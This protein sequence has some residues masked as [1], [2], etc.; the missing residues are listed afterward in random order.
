M[1][2]DGMHGLRTAGPMAGFER[3]P[4]LAAELVE[5]RVSVIAAVGGGLVSR[6]LITAEN[7]DWILGGFAVIGPAFWSWYAKRPQHG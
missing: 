3:L 7:W 4:A 5:Q 1:S 6:G 2:K